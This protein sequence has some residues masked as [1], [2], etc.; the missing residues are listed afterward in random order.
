L[1]GRF[2]GKRAGR[3]WEQIVR[4][5]VADDHAVVRAGLK[6][7]LNAREGWEI[8]GEAETGEEAVALAQRLRPDVVIVDLNM[9]GI[10]GLQ[11]ISEIKQ[12]VPGT[13]LVILTCHY[14]V[15]LLQ[16]IVKAGALGFV[17]KSDANRDLI[18]AV[19]AVGRREPFISRH[20]DAVLPETLTPTPLFML[21]ADSELLTSQERAQVRTIAKQMRHLL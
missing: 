16:A 14:S 3:N 12:M 8:C 19:E 4:I 6:L 20:T 15:P 18:A 21:L 5:L 17:M 7:I 9:P 1:I 10:T 11:A 13:E 2:S